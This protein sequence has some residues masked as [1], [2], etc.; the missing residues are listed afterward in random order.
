MKKKNFLLSFVFLSTLLLVLSACNKEQD[1][2]LPYKADSLQLPTEL[3]NYS[4]VDFPEGFQLHGIDQLHGVTDEVA[5]IGRV[6]FYDTK[7]S[8][9][10]KVSCGSCHKQEFAFADP[11]AT[12]TGFDGRQTTRNAQSIINCFT[13]KSFF[14]DSRVRDLGKMVLEPIGNHIEMGLE[15]LDELEVKLASTDYYPPLF[16]AAYGS[17]EITKEKIADGLEQFLLAMVSIDS[18]HDR[19]GGEFNLD[20]SKLTPSELSGAEIFWGRGSCGDCHGGKDLRGWGDE[21]IAN[22]GLDIEYTDQGMGEGAF[23]VPSLRNVALTAPYMHD[24]RF[25]SL[26]DVINHYNEGIQDHPNLDFRLRGTNGWDPNGPPRRLNLSDED[27]EDL[28]A[29]L[30]TFTDETFITDEKFSD[31]FTR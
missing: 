13:K 28:I 4:D 27:I 6:L 15:E 30:N 2:P 18:K 24:G 21:D 5:T 14:W 11:V 7:L 8:V 1:E 3:A 10:N 26:R 31:P 25:E 19:A 20:F 12:S 9:N 23:Q 17:P 29:L 22:I 16:T